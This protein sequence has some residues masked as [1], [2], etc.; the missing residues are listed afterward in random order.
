[1]QISGNLEVGMVHYISTEISIIVVDSHVKSS[2]HSRY[3]Q[4]IKQDNKWL[5]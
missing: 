5:H 4:K 1:M 3:S 2:Y